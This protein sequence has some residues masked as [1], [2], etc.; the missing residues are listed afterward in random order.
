[1][2]SRE[3]YL[4]SIFEKRDRYLAEQRKRRR[5]ALAFCIPV[6]ACAA[7]VSLAVFGSS[8]AEIAKSL[9]SAAGSSLNGDCGSE[10]RDDCLLEED[11]CHSKQKN[12]IGEQD[13]CEEYDLQETAQGAKIETAAASNSLLS[14]ESSTKQ[15]APRDDEEKNVELFATA[16]NTTTVPSHGSL[17]ETTSK[18]TAENLPTRVVDASI[19]SSDGSAWTY[20]SE[21]DYND[22]DEAFIW[23]SK[24]GLESLD[25]TEKPTG[26]I[27]TV[28]MAL[29]DGTVHI[30]KWSGNALCDETGRWKAI[31]DSRKNAIELAIKSGG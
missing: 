5:T 11:L 15:A 19:S 30:F 13:G 29:S 23:A 16:G 18:N 20:S 24:G 10:Y 2:K 31:S 17:P 28:S 8:R 1:M 14:G 6:T 9:D 26:E 12:E 3:D 22:F 7:V 25:D 4:E 21:K 27:F